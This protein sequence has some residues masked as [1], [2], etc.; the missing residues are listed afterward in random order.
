MGPL[1]ARDRLTR[2]QRGLVRVSILRAVESMVAVGLGCAACI[3]AGVGP[4]VVLAG[5][6]VATGL[7]LVGDQWVRSSASRLLGPNPS[8]AAPPVL[9]AAIREA[10]RPLGIDAKS[11]YVRHVPQR[12]EAQHMGF[13][14]GALPVRSGAVL[15]LGDV[16][17]ERAR[18]AV[19]PSAS[20]GER[21]FAYDEVRA[22]LA[23]ELAHIMP[24]TYSS[25]R[26]VALSSRV[27]TMTVDAVFWAFVFTIEP[28]VGLAGGAVTGI[29]RAV[30]AKV[31]RVKAPL[32]ALCAVAGIAV[33]VLV[34]QEYAL[35]ALYALWAPLRPVP[36]LAVQRRIEHWCD[37]V[38]LGTGA[39]PSALA[40]M[41]QRFEPEVLR[42]YQPPLW[43][44]LNATHPQLHKRIVDLDHSTTS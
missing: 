20:A 9:A 39:D 3:V 25:A 15:L 18:D 36:A 21:R 24:G 41:L 13:A 14:A 34:T 1:M 35:A 5:L 28:W 38:A 19:A 23:H 29:L 44:A 16:V 43:A 31:K 27:S 10:A 4:L 22:V 37:Q 12:G 26:F 11:V 17:A 42:Y 7:A 32:D 8:N 2:A 6:G 30:T 33:A 40:R